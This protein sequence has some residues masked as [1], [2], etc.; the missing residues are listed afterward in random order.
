MN[1]NN[2]GNDTENLAE[3]KYQRHY[4]LHKP[5]ME[6]LTIAL[7]PVLWESYDY[8]SELLNVYLK[9][10]VKWKY[11]SFHLSQI[12]ETALRFGK[13]PGFDYLSFC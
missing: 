11:F 13:F 5:Y 2:W 10:E 7:E 12:S 1:T 9:H 4:F 3:N 8:L 6:W